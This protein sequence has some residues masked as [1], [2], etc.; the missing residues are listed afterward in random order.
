VTESS[1]SKLAE[2]VRTFSRKHNIRNVP[3]SLPSELYIA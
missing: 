1:G 2:T 3:A